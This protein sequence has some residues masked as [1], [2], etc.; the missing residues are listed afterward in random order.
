[1]QKSDIIIVDGKE[2]EMPESRLLREVVYMYSDITDEDAFFAKVNGK[3]L[4]SILDNIDIKVEP[5]DKI[6]IYHLVVGG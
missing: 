5:G 1:M 2:R 3:V 6:E 4:S